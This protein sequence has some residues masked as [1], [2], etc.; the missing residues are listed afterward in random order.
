MTVRTSESSDDAGREHPAPDV[1]PSCGTGVLG[2]AR[3]VAHELS[4]LWRELQDRRRAPT[5]P[6]RDHDTQAQR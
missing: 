2:R 4:D 1:L 3:F 5:R 6:H